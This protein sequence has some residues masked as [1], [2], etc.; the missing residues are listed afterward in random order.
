MLFNE[1]LRQELKAYLRSHY[2]EPQES[3]CYYSI[4]F[5]YKKALEKLINNGE[6]TY[7]DMLFRL[8]DEK[9]MT[10]VQCYKK[11]HLSRKLFSRIRS[12]ED[13]HP[14]EET[15]LALG[16]ALELSLP[17]LKEFIGKAGYA[18]TKTDE[19]DVIVAFFV[20]KKI[21]DLYVINDALAEFHCPPLGQKRR[22]RTYCH[23]L[24]E[25]IIAK[26]ETK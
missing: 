21:Y 15:L 16:V 1:Q 12:E 9:G 14:S 8:I 24:K 23:H 18:L 20:E 3:A 11:A 13:Y 19:Q 7:R 25:K 10:D 4:Y 26:H 6:E 2:E 22:I 17:E 5:D